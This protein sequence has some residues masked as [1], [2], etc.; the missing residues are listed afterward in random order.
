MLAPM[1]SSTDHWGLLAILLLASA[2][3]LWAERTRFGAKLSGCVIAIAITFVLSNVGVIP[4][5]APVYDIVWSYLLPLAIPMLLFRA[6][7]RRIVREAGPTLVAFVCG[8]VGT[9]VGTVVAYFVVP[10]GTEGWKLAAIFCSTY[11]GGS[12]NYYGAADAVGLTAESGGLL[13]AGVAADNLMMVLYFFLLFALPSLGWLKSRYPT[14]RPERSAGGDD[15][16]SYWQGRELRLL[17]LAT[18]L[19]LASTFCA[20]GFSLASYLGWTG[21]GILVVTA[22]TVSAATLLPGPLGRIRG[23]DVLGTMFMQVFFAV[24]GASANIQKVMEY[25][26]VLCL[27][28]GIILLVH[29]VFV[30]VAGRL[31][32]LDLLEIIIASNAN[33]GGPTTAAAFAIARR[34]DWLVLPAIL[35]GT[36]GYAVATFIGVGL[37]KLLKGG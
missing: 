18:A 7:L 22:L 20:L 9:I 35:C 27:F 19:A 34:W 8:G 10:L 31:L 37:G 33:M 4:D 23:A 2:G 14:R 28:A 15:A 5:Q 21:M 3:G 11:I 36:L 17:D 26:L 13:A 16:T 12:M 24:I 32:K 29:L 1:I 25:G 6:D 30:L